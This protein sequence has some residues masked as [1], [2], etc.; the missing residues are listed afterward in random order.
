[1]TAVGDSTVMAIMLSPLYLWFGICFEVVDFI[2]VCNYLFYCK[3][4]FVLQFETKYFF[5]IYKGSE[6]QLTIK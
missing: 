1:V 2:T 6:N 4:Q 5:T 3:K